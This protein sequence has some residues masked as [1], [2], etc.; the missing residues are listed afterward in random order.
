MEFET[1]DEWFEH[2]RWQHAIEWWCDGDDGAHM[3]ESFPERHRYEEHVRTSHHTLSTESHL[4]TISKTAMG[5]VARI[6][7]FC[8]FCDFQ[9]Y[10]HAETVRK[11]GE[12]FNEPSVITMSTSAAQIQLRAHI[13]NH[14]LD[15]FIYALPDRDDIKEHN[16][17]TRSLGP[18]R[19]TVKDLK[20]VQLTAGEE[21]DELM[22]N[23]DTE[24][25]KTNADLWNTFHE[26]QTIEKGP[27]T[28]HDNDHVIRRFVAARTRKYK[29]SYVLVSICSHPS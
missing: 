5:P 8:P 24:L 13:A 25:P 28:G 17:A 11:A 7:D 23:T 3:P 4:Q 29:I 20:E 15:L 21:V 19:S 2:Q 16:S 14:L 27:Y 6:F 22:S 10:Q 18:A 26:W 1:E 12:K 9:S